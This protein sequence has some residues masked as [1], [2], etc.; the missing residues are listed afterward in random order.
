VGDRREIHWN[1]MALLKGKKEK[2]R[3]KKGKKGM[4]K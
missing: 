4:G 3:K 1:N 2:E